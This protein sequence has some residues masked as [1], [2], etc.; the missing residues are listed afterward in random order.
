MGKSLFVI[1]PNR[2]GKR[3]MSWG[4]L[5]DTKNYFP[6]CYRLLL[7]MWLCRFSSSLEIAQVLPHSRL[8]ILISSSPS[9]VP[10]RIYSQLRFRYSSLSNS[11]RGNR[12][13]ITSLFNLRL[14]FQGSDSSTLESSPSLNWSLMRISASSDCGRSPFLLFGC[15]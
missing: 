6:S 10:Y 15:C 1:F 5:E 8:I 9:S 12:I 14:S 13:L 2:L 7:H 3:D 11:N 4:H